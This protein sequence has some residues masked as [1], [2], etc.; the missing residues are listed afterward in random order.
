MAIAAIDSASL[1]VAWRQKDPFDPHAFRL[2]PQNEEQ[3]RRRAA[4][5]VAQAQAAAFFER[6]ACSVQVV[7]LVGGEIHS[8]L[9]EPPPLLERAAP[10]TSVASLS[11]T[12]RLNAADMSMLVSGDAAGALTMW[13]CRAHTRRGAAAAHEGGVVCQNRQWVRAGGLQFVLRP[14]QGNSSCGGGGGRSEG[15]RGDSGNGGGGEGVGERGQ[16]G[17]GVAVVCMQP[18]D[19]EHV[20]A[21]AIL[22][23][24]IIWIHSYTCIC[25]CV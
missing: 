11:T 21:G 19:K 15:G 22:H 12:S 7:E 2:V 20:L 9:L 8:S 3:R 23:P 14:L 25:V 5:E 6:I 18:L 10:V 1:A 16:E 17:G 13:T 4:A 24:E